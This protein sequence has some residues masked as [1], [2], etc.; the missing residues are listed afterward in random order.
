MT[1]QMNL[2]RLG[3]RTLVAGG[4]AV[5]LLVPAAQAIEIEEVVSPKGIKAWLMNDPSD[6]MISISFSFEGGDLQD[7]AGKEGLTPLMID[8]M[9]KGAGDLDREAFATRLYKT[10]TGFSLRSS[11]DLVS[12]SIKL[13]PGE[14][15]EPLELL[16][17]ALKAPRFDQDA[18]DQAKGVVYAALE[19]KKNDPD[20]LGWEKFGKA[21]YGEHPLGSITTAET[22][23]AITRDDLIERHKALFARSNLT[24]GVAGNISKEEL[25]KVL[26]DVFGDLPEKA[27]VEPVAPPEPKFGVTVHQ[28][29]N[30]PQTSIA[31]VYPGIP[32][33]SQDLY[34]SNVLVNLMGGGMTSR[35]FMELR[36]KRGLTYGAGASSAL[37]RDWGLVYVSTSTRAASANEA[38]EVARDVVKQIAEGDI[39]QKEVD[40]AKSY[41]KGAVIMDSLGTTSQI[42]RTLVNLQRLNR[43]IDYL[44]K[45]EKL[46]EAVTLEDVKKLA[47]KL[48]SQEPAVLIVGQGD[49]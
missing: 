12:G 23:K 27:G 18:I 9:D 28:A 20:S 22:I 33:S 36:E 14:E 35:L 17:L 24:V 43:P 19:D 42:A 37:S 5:M 10:G 40:A 39:S 31:L 46:Y 3:F 47:A 26:D 45:L 49:S 8:L 4:F 44:D 34:T 1:I 6:Q 2:L 30:R 7:P 48:L 13:L 29:Y 15:Q 16:A 32:N 38:L 41:M 11:S 21:F 25:S